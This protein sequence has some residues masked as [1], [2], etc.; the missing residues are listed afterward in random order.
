MKKIV[1]ISMV[2]M[3]ILLGACTC[4]NAVTEAELE[5]YITSTH[6]VAGKEVTL[7]SSEL[8]QVRDYFAENDITD[9]QAGVI[10]AKID[11]C[12]AIMNKEGVTDVKK[13]TSASKQEMLKKAQEAAEVV[14]L[15]VDM[16][17]G[18]VTNEAGEPVFKLPEGKLV[19]T[20]SSNI[21]YVLAI[22]AI[23]AV[24][25]VVTYKKVTK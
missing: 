12:L 20:G 2:S 14:N 8:K 5:K 23:I 3:L 16:S 13:L 18:L 1:I 11:E 10:K 24:A 21:G 7:T 15:K 6:I 19:Q 22:F 17:T 25:G 9:E 4:V